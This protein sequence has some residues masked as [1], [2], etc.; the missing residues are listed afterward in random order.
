MRSLKYIIFFGVLLLVFGGLF[1]IIQQYEKQQAVEERSQVIP[2]FE[3]RNMDGS[4]FSRPD[5]ALG[6]SVLFFFFSPT[7]EHCRYETG[8]IIRNRTKLKN[9]TTIFVSDDSRNEVK[10]FISDY[11]LGAYPEFNVLLDTAQ[12]SIVDFGIPGAPSTYIYD[13][14]FDLAKKFRGEVKFEAVEKYLN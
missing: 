2:A 1:L 13:K 10:K 12:Y 11:D 4:V 14:N 5:L 7:C 6:K 3:F 9:V 8:E